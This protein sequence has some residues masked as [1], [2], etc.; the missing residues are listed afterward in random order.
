MSLRGDARIVDSSGSPSN[1]GL[2][3]IRMKDRTS[4]EYGTVCGMNLVRMWLRL[5]RDL[6]TCVATCLQAAADVLCSQ[7]GY[8]YGTVSTSACGQYGGTNM[9]G[10]PGAP[11]AV[12]NL[13]CDGSELGIQEC[14][15]NSVPDE[16]CLDH[17]ADSIVYCGKTQ[18]TADNT[19]RLLSHDGSPSLDGAGRPEI[20]RNG[21][22]APIC[23]A[24]FTEGAASVLCKAMGFAG[25]QTFQQSVSCANYGGRNFCGTEMPDI[26]EVSCSGQEQSIA[27]CSFEE[28]DDVFCAP[29]ESV[30]LQCSGIGRSQGRFAQPIVEVVG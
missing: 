4:E 21:R 12:S 6:L 30:V 29:Q 24:G 22:W 7:L 1:V 27:D 2:V 28:G 13:L 3:Q 25:S 26:S 10:A 16:K 17:R 15:Y 20:F 19:I 5:F 9:C 14:A 11:I 23:K 18:T 8:D